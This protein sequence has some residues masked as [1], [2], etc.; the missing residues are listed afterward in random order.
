MNGSGPTEPKLFRSGPPGE[1][2]RRDENAALSILSHYLEFWL[3]CLLTL[4]ILL[5]HVRSVKLRT[6]DVPLPFWFTTVGSRILVLDP[7]IKNRMNPIA[8]NKHHGDDDP[9]ATHTTTPTLLRYTFTVVSGEK[10][11]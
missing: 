1:L 3:V 10:V 4:M 2:V 8:N 9:P 11:P 6:L 5:V 7:S